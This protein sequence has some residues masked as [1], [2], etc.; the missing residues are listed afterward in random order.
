[1]LQFDDVRVRVG[2]STV[3]IIVPCRQKMRKDK[4][5]A[6]ARERYVSIQSPPGTRLMVSITSAS[7][8]GSFNGLSC[9]GGAR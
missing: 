6:K 2:V 9:R 5:S 3:M 7:T 4:S 1:M 8:F